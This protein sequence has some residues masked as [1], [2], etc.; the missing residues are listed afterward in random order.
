MITIAGRKALKM[1][2]KKGFTLIELMFAIVIIAISVLAVYQ[3]YIQ[4]SQMIT[5]EYHRRLAFEKAQEKIEIA[6]S[7]RSFCDTVP[8]S[9]SGTFT[10]ALD[11]PEPGQEES[12]MATYIFKVEHSQD[13]DANGL[14]YMSTVTIIYEW[15]E[16]S[17]RVLSFKLKTYVIS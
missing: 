17:G 8:R 6:K 15:A 11:V 9:L 13:R 2:S 4:G 10:E 16:R 14:P 5:E 7:Y 1:N 12:I 3:M